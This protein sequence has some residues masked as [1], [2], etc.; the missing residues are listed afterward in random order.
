MSDEK[1][2]IK[3]DKIM[4][5]TKRIKECLEWTGPCF[6]RPSGK[7]TYP[8]MYYKNKVWRG[9]RLVWTL[10]NG[11]IPPGKLICHKCDN[12]RCVN[13]NHL[14]LGTYFDNNRDMVKRGRHAESR[15]TQCPYGHPYSG[16]NLRTLKGKR[17]CRSCAW[18]KNRGLKVMKDLIYGA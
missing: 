9:N 18:Y 17:Y 5:R 4:A 11:T 16:Q 8:Y 12:P 15:K 14:Y 1:P 13:P 7:K 3:L 6:R 10:V 2:R